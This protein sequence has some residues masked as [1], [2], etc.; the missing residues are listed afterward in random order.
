MRIERREVA[1]VRACNRT[2]PRFRLQVRGLADPK[3]DCRLGF[4]AQFV[5]L[6]TLAVRSFTLEFHYEENPA[7]HLGTAAV[8]FLFSRI[9]HLGWIDTGIEA[10]CQS[11]PLA[12]ILGPPTGRGSRHDPDPVCRIRSCSR[13]IRP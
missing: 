1:S 12:S 7:I 9:Q 3:V 6:L 11:Q 13:A 2:L 5:D 10:G 4:F 8:C